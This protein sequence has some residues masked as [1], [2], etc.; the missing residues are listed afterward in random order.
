MGMFGRD[1]AW[2]LFGKPESLWW[3]DRSILSQFPEGG[4]SSLLQQKPECS[5]KQLTQAIENA[6][7]V[8]RYNMLKRVSDFGLVSY[9]NSP[10]F[11]SECSS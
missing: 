11:H 4:K 1:Y 6:L 7:I 8:D 5:L 2:I 10:C 3:K 9:S